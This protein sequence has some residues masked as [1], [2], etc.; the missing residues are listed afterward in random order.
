MTAMTELVAWEDLSELEQLE[1]TYCDMHKDV[2]GVKAG[3][4]A[5]KKLL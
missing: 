1:A 4:D 5:G 3:P 2:Y